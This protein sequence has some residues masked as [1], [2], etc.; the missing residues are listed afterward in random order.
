[1]VPSVTLPMHQSDG[2][3]FINSVA[4]LTFWGYITDGRNVIPL[5]CSSR[6][7]LVITLAL[8]MAVVSGCGRAE[9]QEQRR[10]VP[11]ALAGV[12][13]TDQ[14]GK[15]LGANELGG[16]PLVVSFMFTSCP[17]VCPR[18]TRALSQVR[19]GLSSWARERV[20]LLSLSV[21][22]EH[23]TP[24]K[25]REFALENGA[26]LE[27][28]AFARSSADGTRTLT[29]RLAAFD[30]G[31]GSE[32]SGHSTA[33]YLFDAR[34]TLLQRYGGAIDVARLTREIERVSE[35]SGAAAHGAD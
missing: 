27:G 2:T 19:R 28:W 12:T 11:A 18:Q 10:A 6:S 23:D 5:A 35:L 20:Q 8:L 15:P 31:T 25:L 30:A 22:P 3:G 4:R 16:K 1:V 13:L 21:D 24:A 26:D 33:A 7:K 17:S 32:P 9:A 34:G 29:T 14:D